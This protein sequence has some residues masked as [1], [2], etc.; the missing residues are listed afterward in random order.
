MYV[1]HQG[2]GKNGQVWYVTS[3]N[4]A[5][6]AADQQIPNVGMSASPSAVVFKDIL[7]LF[8]QGSRESG[9]LWCQTF[10]GSAWSSAR[11]LTSVGITASPSAVVFA[12]GKLYLFHRGPR[13]TGE[14]WVTSTSDG[15][16]WSAD[17]QI[18]G[19][20]A[21]WSPGAVE[22][23]GRLNVFYQGGGNNGQLWKYVHES[24]E[25]IGV[26]YDL[27]NAKT[28]ALTT[29]LIWTRKVTNDTSVEQTNSVSMT[30]S[31]DETSQFENSSSGTVSMEVGRTFSA[32]IP[33]VEAEVGGSFTLGVSQT[34]TCTYGQSVTISKSYT[35]TVN[36]TIPPRSVV[37]VSFSVSECRL[38]VPYIMRFRSKDGYTSSCAGTWMGLTT[39]NLQPSYSQPSTL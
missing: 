1:F 26:D 22:A 21:S 28:Y 15:T 17:Q 2:S 10:N 20:S 16:N 34:R 29:R 36:V 7:Y 27:N 31:V 33:V 35:D 24:M 23:M 3:S 6:W 14:L 12:T 39:W 5:N 25:I 38:D 11:K 30:A 19:V 18:N 8:Y 37:T 9:E 13:Q 4:G 32:G